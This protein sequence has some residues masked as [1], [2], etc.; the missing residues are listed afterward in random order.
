M[1]SYNDKIATNPLVDLVLVSR[2]DSKS[3]ALKWSKQVKFPWP[4]IMKTDMSK[5]LQKHAGNGVPNYVL[6]DQSGTILARGKA[7]SFAKIAELA[8]EA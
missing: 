8:P 6:M 7:A 3:D 2:D 1:K 5:F 4:Q